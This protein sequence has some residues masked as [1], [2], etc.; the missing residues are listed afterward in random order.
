MDIRILGPLEVLDDG[1]ALELGGAKQRA[2]LAVLALNANRAVTVDQLASALWDEAPPDTARKAIQVYVSQLRKTLGKERVQTKGGSYLLR[3]GPDELD[4]DRFEALRRSG[5]LDGALAAFRG[6]PLP[7]LGDRGEAR[8]LEELRLSC[9]EERLDRDLA[10]GRHAEVVGEL[11]ALVHANPLRE[12]LRVQLML[13][14]YRSGRQAEALDAY[15]AARD[16][17][18]DELGLEPS[19]E[20]RELH[21]RVLQQDAGLDLPTRRDPAP[22]EAARPPAGVMRK[23]VTVLFCDLADSTELGERLDPEALRS[24]M[25]RWYDAMRAPIERAGGTVEKFVGDAVMAVFGVPAVHEDDAFRAVRAAV[26]MREAVE[27]LALHIRIGVNTGEVVTGDGE[28]TLVTGDA[29]NTAKRLEE[30]AAAGEILIGAATRRLVAHASELEPVGTVAAKGKRAPVQAWRVLSTIAGASPFPRRLDAPLV[31]RERE[32]ARLVSELDAAAAERTCRLVTICGP[33]GVGK[34]RLAQELLARADA[35]VLRARCAPYGDGITFLPLRDL[36][37]DVPGGSNDEI[38]WDVRRQL[39]ERAQERPLLVCVEDV[40]WAQPAFLD[41]LEYVHGWS[42]DAPLLLVCLARPELYDT[43]PRWPGTAVMLDPLTTEESTALLDELDVPADARA[44]IAEAAEGNPLFLEQ[45][46]AMLAD[47]FPAEMPPTIHA[48]LTARLDRLEPFE[49]S[50]LQRAAVV[51]KDF[52]RNAVVE[53]SPEHE[54]ADVT[55]T[56]F[57]LTRKELVRPDHSAFADEDGFRFRHALIRDAAYAEVPKRVRAELHERLADRLDRQ[58]AEGALVGYHL[59]QA[60]CAR[61]ELGEAD[62]GLAARAG[63]LLAAAGRTAS[64]R[65]DMPAARNLFE[66]ALALDDLLDHRPATLR[67]LAGAR[68]ATGDIEG[69][70]AAIDEAIEVAARS[71][72]VRQEW[73]ARLER[74]ARMHQL[75]AADD[76]LGAV[77]TEAIRVFSSLGDDAGLCRAW[78]RLALLSYSSGRCADAAGQAERALEHARKAGDAAEI[79]RT[80]DLYCSALVYGPEPAATAT[81]RCRELLAE[82]TPGRVL[83]AAVASALAYLAAMQASFDEAH[84]HAARAAAIYEE[85][86]LPLLRAGLAQVIGAIEILADDLAA[87][88]REFLLGRKLFTDAGA[89]P[90]AGHLAALLARVI[91]ERGRADDASDLVAVALASV[92]NHDLAGFVNTRL[93]AATLAEVRGRTDDAAALTAEAIARLEGTD[94]ILLA[95]ALAA[96]GDVDAA[97]DLHERKGNVAAAALV[98]ARAPR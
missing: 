18:M 11:E 74:A 36:L 31:G 89:K 67:G 45:M 13:A 93:A 86:G 77:S 43:R 95:D 57:S 24:V 35:E 68:W 37:G 52:S 82:G 46:V 79:A 97:I 2:V 94:T 38:F 10:D 92:D 83:E 53:L 75:H 14:L 48:L 84:E 19:R 23:T 26:E 40:H 21:Q 28:T 70:A 61:A 27:P 30:A 16:T 59:E 17:F 47:E 91:L 69:A 50:V 71:G 90:L 41:L 54:R 9:L 32:L 20:L 1:R 5:D 65:D 7:D 56:L 39:Q 42:R 72:D 29:V 8:R 44:R 81:Q 22:K 73:Y 3:V 66:R 15:R 33:A 4:L 78:R 76:E 80:A 49:Q 87:A 85:L 98:T 51:G 63:A 96:G 34:S 62:P 64:A 60:A 12:H 6:E 55:A 88:E 58:G 25:T